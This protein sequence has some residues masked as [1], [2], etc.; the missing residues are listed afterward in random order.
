MSSRKPKGTAS[1]GAAERR[2][3]P[4]QPAA[5]DVQAKAS[6]PAWQCL[7]TRSELGH[8]KKHTHLITPPTCCTRS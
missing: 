1:K 7:A 4:P 5:P 2:K 6:A 3:P 8:L